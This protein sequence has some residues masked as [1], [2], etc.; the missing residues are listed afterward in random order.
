MQRIVSP[1][2]QRRTNTLVFQT[3]LGLQKIIT[4]LP[5]QIERQQPVYFIDA[6]SKQAPFHLEF[7]RS[8]EVSWRCIAKVHYT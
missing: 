3:V 2:I 7:V 4:A 5:G 8:A 6:L 1:D